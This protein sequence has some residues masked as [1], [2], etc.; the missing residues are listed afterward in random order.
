MNEIKKTEDGNKF[1]DT[2]L[3]N[4]SIFAVI[5]MHFWQPNNYV[6]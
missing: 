2:Q 5:I 4:I 6:L 1:S 3:K